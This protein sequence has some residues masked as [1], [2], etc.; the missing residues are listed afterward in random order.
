MNTKPFKKSVQSLIDL[1]DQ[2]WEMLFTNVEVHLLD[3]NSFFL[4]EGQVCEAVAFVTTGSLIYFKLHENGNEV[5]TDFALEGDWVADNH[6]RLNNS[7]SF[8]NIKAI[9]KTELLVINHKNLEVLYHK[10][11]KLERLGRILT[12]QAFIKIVQSNIDFQILTASERYEK[13]VRTRPEVLRRIPLYHI[14]NYLGIAPKSLS[15]LRK[16]N[17]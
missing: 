11:P 2:E 16:N 9:E 1:S 3:K 14:A 15:R 10:I 17:S 8:L 12:E 6:S 4:K 7:P 13:L 5:T